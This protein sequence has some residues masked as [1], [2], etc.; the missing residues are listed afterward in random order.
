MIWLLTAFSIWEAVMATFLSWPKISVNC[1]RM[2]SMS[3]SF[4]IRMM[5]SLVYAMV[6]IPFHH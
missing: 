3:S 4:T 6:G 5:S 2:N 1:M